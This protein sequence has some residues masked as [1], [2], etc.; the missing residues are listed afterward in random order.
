MDVSR[1]VEI[2]RKPRKLVQRKK[3]FSLTLLALPGLIWFFVLCYMPM[4][5]AI[6]AFQNYKPRKGIL[7]SEWV[8]LDNFKY[9]FSSNDATRILGNTLFYNFISIFIVA[10]VAVIIALLMDAVRKRAFVKVYQTLLF[11]PRF[12][13]WVVVGYMATA[14]F[15]YD[16]GLLNHIREI[17]ELEP[18]SWYLTPG[19]WRGILLTANIW[20]VMGYT[21]LIYYGSIMG[22]SPELY[23]SAEIDGASG[24]QKIWHITLPLIRPTIV[25]MMLMSVGSIMKADFGLFYY[26]PNNSGALYPV[27]DVIDT[28]VYRALRGL[29]DFSTSAATSL[30]QSVVGFVLI[31][32]SN[33]VVRKVDEQSSLF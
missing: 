1:S 13:S 12:I 11:L 16:M 30:F 26:V 27:T 7:G 18:V 14:L 23:E 10:A 22:I 31:L 4:G 3:N 17:L 32:L 33:W 19:P 15:H 24:F 5:G 28:Y 9:L 21:S 2:V 25:I 8:G 6:I 29:G 20:K